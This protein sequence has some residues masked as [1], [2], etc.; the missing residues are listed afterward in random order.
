[1]KPLTLLGGSV[2][3]KFLLAKL[4]EGDKEVLLF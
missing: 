1:M 4:E 2:K 3:A